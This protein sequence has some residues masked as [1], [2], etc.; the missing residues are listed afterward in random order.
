MQFGLRFAWSRKAFLS[1]AKTSYTESKTQDMRNCSGAATQ[2]HMKMIGNLKAFHL[3][4]VAQSNIAPRTPRDGPH[5]GQDGLWVAS[6][7]QGALLSGILAF[8][9]SI[10]QSAQPSFRAVTT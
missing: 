2:T 6:W 9:A 1:I 7:R 8:D 10:V 3:R 5:G 4:Q